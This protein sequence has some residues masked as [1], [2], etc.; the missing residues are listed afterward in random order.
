M[1]IMTSLKNKIIG[2]KIS[3]VFPEGNEPR[4]VQ[5]ASLLARENMVH[6]ILLGSEADVKKSSR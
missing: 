6:P 2:K 3:I 4:V 1:D 5:A